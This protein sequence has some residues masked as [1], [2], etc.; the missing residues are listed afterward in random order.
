[1]DKGFLSFYNLLYNQFRSLK[2]K[3][4][5]FH[6]YLPEVPNELDNLDCLQVKGIDGSCNH[7]E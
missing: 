6:W 7:E 1:M 4:S 3:K 5:I 2:K